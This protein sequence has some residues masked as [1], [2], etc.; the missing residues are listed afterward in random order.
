MGVQAAPRAVAATARTRPGCTAASAWRRARWT[1]ATCCSPRRLLASSSAASSSGRTFRVGTS[2][3]PTQSGSYSLLQVKKSR[4]LPQSSHAC[5]DG[6]FPP[7]HS[8]IAF[9]QLKWKRVKGFLGGACSGS[10]NRQRIIALDKCYECAPHCP[11][12]FLLHLEFF[13]LLRH[14]LCKFFFVRIM[15][16]SYAEND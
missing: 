4:L 1:A 6:C 5:H 2:C 9:A 12:L 11:F 14:Y 8:P 16:C 3:R 7:L 13:V 10:L 15:F